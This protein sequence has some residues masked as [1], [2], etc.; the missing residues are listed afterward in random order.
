MAF[1]YLLTM[2]MRVARQ[3]KQKFESQ[4]LDKLFKK[5]RISAIKRYF[6]NFKLKL[7]II[8]LFVGKMSSMVSDLASLKLR[9]R[10][11]SPN[12]VMKHTL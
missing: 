3:C 12:T 4:K 11:F 8:R 6:Q 2:S 9:S 1:T 7:D 5:N 10:T